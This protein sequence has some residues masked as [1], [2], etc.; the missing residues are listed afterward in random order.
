MFLPQKKVWYLKN[1]KHTFSAI[2]PSFF[3]LR[4][5][6]PVTKHFSFTEAIIL[7]KLSIFYYVINLSYQ[8][9]S[10]TPLKKKGLFSKVSLTPPG[11]WCYFD[12]FLA[13][14]KRTSFQISFRHKFVQ[15]HIQLFT[16]AKARHWDFLIFLRTN[17]IFGV[18]LLVPKWK[19][20]KKVFSVSKIEWRNMA[21]VKIRTNRTQ[22][23]CMHWRPATKLRFKNNYTVLRKIRNQ[24]FMHSTW[25]PT[26]NFAT[27]RVC[28]K[29]DVKYS[30]WTRQR[31]CK[32]AEWM[33]PKCFQGDVIIQ[34]FMR[35]C[36]AIL[37]FFLPSAVHYGEGQWNLEKSLRFGVSDM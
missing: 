36:Q 9:S 16:K 14:T 33:V 11:S 7:G 31:T 13:V 22:D 28:N 19:F 10:V 1:M 23:S 34:V 32:N 12:S 8:K 25:R 37:Q 29:N 2:S 35:S 26:A 24:V 30:F 4:S 27:R 6:P 21:C 3:F 5:T 17:E 18:N 15:H 20:R